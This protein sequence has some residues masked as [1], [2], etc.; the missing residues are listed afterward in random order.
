MTKPSS[1]RILSK[2]TRLLLNKTSS[3]MRVAKQAVA[4]S[5]R[6]AT[7]LP[8][9]SCPFSYRRGGNGTIGSNEAVEE[10]VTVFMVDRD[11]GARSKDA[12]KGSDVAVSVVPVEDL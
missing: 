4:E 3:R 6:E 11:D 8:Q 2:S 10:L 9:P 1:K 12:R 5:W 7:S